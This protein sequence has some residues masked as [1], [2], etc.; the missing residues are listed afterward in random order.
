M[1]TV[2]TGFLTLLRRRIDWL[3][4]S[5]LPSHRQEELLRRAEESLYRPLPGNSSDVI[6]H[7]NRQL[8][9]ELGIKE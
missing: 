7:L 9:L 2:N 1:A 6:D 3:K 4:D 5:K 8:R